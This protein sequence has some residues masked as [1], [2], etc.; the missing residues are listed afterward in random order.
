MNEEQFAEFLVVLHGM[1][2]TVPS[3]DDRMAIIRHALEVHERVHDG[4]TLTVYLQDAI[5]DYFESR[6]AEEED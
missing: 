3:F 5:E 1:V 6:I 2:D 4:R